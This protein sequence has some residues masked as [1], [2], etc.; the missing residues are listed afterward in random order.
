MNEANPMEKVVEALRAA[1]T[2]STRDDITNAA[3]M[4]SEALP[5]AQRL[6]AALPVVESVLQAA[7]ERCE[8]A[9]AKFSARWAGDDEL[10]ARLRVA[11]RALQGEQE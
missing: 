6:Q 8:T 11:L 1:Y 9:K 3:E 10:M 2:I 7:L 5:I 4:A